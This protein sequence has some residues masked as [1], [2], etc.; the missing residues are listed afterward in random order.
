MNIL[1]VKKCRSIKVDSIFESKNV[2]S[3][4]FENMCHIRSHLPHL[5]E[6]GDFKRSMFYKRPEN[7]SNIGFLQFCF[8]HS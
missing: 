1:Q 5:L 6:K 2:D 4:S 7:V 8:Q 3:C